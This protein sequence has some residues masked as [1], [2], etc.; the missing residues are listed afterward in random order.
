[1]NNENYI[2]ERIISISND[3]IGYLSS[4]QTKSATSWEIKMHFKIPSSI[5]YLALGNL[6]ANKKIKITAE[7]LI[8]KIDLIEENE[9]TSNVENP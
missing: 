2:N 4:T 1:M 3:I 7:N 9:M 6:I 5:L 8:Y